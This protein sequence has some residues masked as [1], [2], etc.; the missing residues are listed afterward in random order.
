NAAKQVHANW[1]LL[2]LYITKAFAA[3][4]VQAKLNAA[5]AA[6]YARKS[7]DN[8]SALR[9]LIDIA[10]S[11]ITDNLVALTANDNMPEDFRAKFQNDGSNCIEHSMI[12]TQAKMDKQMATS[13]KAKANNSI[14]TSA[15]EMLKDGQ[16]IFKGDA[17]TKKQ[18]TF[19]YLVSIYQ[20]EG[21][22]SLKGYVVNE[23][24][25]PIEG[26]TVMSAD[27]KY[28]AITDA[29]GYYR[30]TRIAE[31]TYVFNVTCAGFIPLTQQIT[32]IA[33]TAARGDFELVNEMKRVA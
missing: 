33:G 2:K 16:Q 22:A 18:F 30:I 15:I 7:F 9:C 27:Q 10:N 4:M 24:N 3:D 5:G 20:G 13:A 26:V 25:L 17:A 29:K 32:F 14:Y 23:F 31:G 28:S 19:S 11:F 1:Q 6:L 8:W 21:S 12:F